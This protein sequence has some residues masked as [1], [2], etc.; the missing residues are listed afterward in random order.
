[1]KDMEDQVLMSSRDEIEEFKRSFLWTDIEEE[2]DRISKNAQIEYDLVGESI[3]N[4]DGVK[5]TPTT[6]EILLHMGDIKGRRKSVEY[7]R[8]L[9]DIF[10]QTLEIQSEDQKDDS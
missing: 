4:D 8:S 7:F 3:T 5:V 2:L 10:L 6:A 9:P 1:M